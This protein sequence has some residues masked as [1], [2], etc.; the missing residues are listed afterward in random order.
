MLSLARADAPAKLDPAPK[1]FDVRRDD[2]KQGKVETVEYD[3]KSAKTRLKMVV[4][5][6]PGYSKEHKYPVLYL[7]HGA[8][9]NEEGWKNRG[10][11]NTILDN[12]YADKKAVPMIVVMPNG[13][14]GASSGFGMGT[15]LAGSIVRAAD[16]D[17]DGKK[18]WR[19][20]G[21]AARRSHLL[22]LGT[23]LKWV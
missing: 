22:P 5:T 23:S 19:N 3:S 15:I 1:G 2:V 14:A 18:R 12:L 10:S 17:K 16:T 20:D 8:G 4:Y 11:A 9:D 6:P 13:Y 21:S 7:L